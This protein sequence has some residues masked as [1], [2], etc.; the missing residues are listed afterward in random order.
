MTVAVGAVFNGWSNVDAI[1]RFGS[2]DS[3]SSV[4]S[5]DSAVVPSTD[6]RAAS[7][8]QPEGVTEAGT[9]V[10]QERGN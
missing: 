6:R 3:V 7:S 9:G 1:A 2:L 10:R 4:D 8:E 5:S